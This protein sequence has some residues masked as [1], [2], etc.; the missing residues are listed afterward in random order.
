MKLSDLTQVWRVKSSIKPDSSR[1]A[2]LRGGVVAKRRWH[3]RLPV[4]MMW[5]YF[6]HSACREGGFGGCDYRKMEEPIHNWMKASVRLWSA[7]NQLKAPV[8]HMSDSVIHQIN[9]YPVDMFEGNQKVF[10]QL[11][12]GT[13]AVLFPCGMFHYCLLQ[14]PVVQKVEYIT[15]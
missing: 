11:C 14:V 13:P 15:L 5:A 6:L 1:A 3:F 12:S 4:T 2:C 7:S 8:V 10:K 9:N